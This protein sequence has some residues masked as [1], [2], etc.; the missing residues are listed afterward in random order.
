MKKNRLSVGESTPNFINRSYTN[1]QAGFI[2]T[3]TTLIEEEQATSKKTRTRTPKASKAV[4]PKATP[5][6]NG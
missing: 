3:P 4:K 1:D 6:K 5:K 2:I